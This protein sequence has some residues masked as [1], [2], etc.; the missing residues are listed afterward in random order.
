LAAHLALTVP[1]AILAF[2]WDLPGREFWSEHLSVDDE[3]SAAALYAG[4]L[5]GVVAAL[6][7]VQ[8]FHPAVPTRGPRWLWVLGWLSVALFA[9]VVAFEEIAGL[10]DALGRAEWVTTLLESVRLSDLPG[11]IRWAAVVAPF[12]AP[13]A[14]AAAWV[15]YA[16]LRRHP[17]LALLTV[18]AVAL[19]VSA[20]LHDGLAH[21][22]GTTGPWLLVLDDGSEFMASAILTVVLVETIAARHSKRPADPE[23]PGGRYR[24][25]A[26]G[27][28]LVALVGVSIPALLAEWEWEEAGWARP[29]HYAGPISQLEQSVQTHVGQLSHLEIWSHV[30][31]GNG[32]PATAEIRPRLISREGGPVIWGT[33]TVSGTRDAPDVSVITF[34]P[35]PDSAGKHYDLVILADVSPRVS[36][37]LTGGGAGIDGAVV[38]DVQ[39]ERKLAIGT[40][41]RLSGA[42]IIGDLLTRDPRR[43]FVVG[44]VVATLFL[45]IFAVTATWR[46]LAGRQPHFWRRCV[47]PPAR[48]SAL[49]TVGLLVITLAETALH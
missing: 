46:G 17:A 27:G 28:L 37:G 40:H 35:I 22:Y 43:L 2:G 8:L 12:A 36:L 18:L 26:T 24:R 5:W 13:L 9:S 47:W 34:E 31:G 20:V 44:E 49:I 23:S 16:S 45:W 21:L 19:G 7:T 15:L 39:H 4:V 25:W 32:A 38:N 11:Q 41:V 3:G 30:D 48:R 10:K 1:L 42:G 33:A 14:V 6:A 29:L